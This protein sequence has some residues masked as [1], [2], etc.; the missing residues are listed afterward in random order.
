MATTTTRPF[1][2]LLLLLLALAAGPWPASAALKRQKNDVGRVAKAIDDG[3]GS[4]MYA[5][6]SGVKKKSG[7]RRLLRDRAGAAAVAPSSPTPTPTT[8]QNH[9]TGVASPDTEGAGVRQAM[10]RGGRH[11][12]GGIVGTTTGA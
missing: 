7:R 10:T 9:H 5:D 11:V 8:P 4:K 2:L 1:F 12:R 3:T 6:V